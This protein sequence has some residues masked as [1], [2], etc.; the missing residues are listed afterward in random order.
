MPN[1]AALYT[2]FNRKDKTLNALKAL[3][4]AQ[5]NYKGNLLVDVYLTDDGSTDGTS[6]AVAK[7]YPNVTIVKGNGNLF[8]AEGMRSSWKKAM[9]TKTYDAYFLLNDDTEL[10]ANVFEQIDKTHN[11]SIQNLGNAGIYL[12][13]TEDKIKKTHT[14]SGSIILSKFL[15]K[16]KRLVPNGTVQ[17]CDLGN[18]NIMWVSSQ[19]VSKIGILTAGYAHGLA[20][21]DYTLTA[22]KNDIPVLLAPE[23]CGHCVNDHNDKYEG[24]SQKTIGE[25]KKIIH[26]PLG[27][28]LKSNLKYMRKF[29]PFRVPFI[30]FFATLKLYF[31]K[32]Y[33]NYF[34][35]R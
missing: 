27:F 2:C 29:F 11:F 25:R 19:V 30:L 15:Y 21:Y 18:A 8:W 17:H 31:P 35:N 10:Y 3:E 32:V 5:K 1:V 12:G 9:D 4:V 14:Y 20:D 23:Y 26:H 6:E 7:A 34:R 16:Q 22:N 13:G 33:L 28:D 24:F